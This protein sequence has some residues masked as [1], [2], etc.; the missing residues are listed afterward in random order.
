M[1]NCDGFEGSK[2]DDLQIVAL[3]LKSFY[4]RDGGFEFGG[5]RG[6]KEDGAPDSFAFIELHK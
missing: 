4:G 3:S 6:S 5:G 2:A 1:I